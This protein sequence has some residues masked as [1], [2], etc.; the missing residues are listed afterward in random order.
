MIERYSYK[1]DADGLNPSQP[2]KD[3]WFVYPEFDEGNPSASTKDGSLA[4]SL[5]VYTEYDEV[6]GFH[7][8]PPTKSR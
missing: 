4:L 6:K 2:T 7:P 5:N 1:V 8:S 3:S